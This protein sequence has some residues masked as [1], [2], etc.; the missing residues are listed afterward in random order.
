MLNS[1]R[2]DLCLDGTHF[3]LCAFSL[4]IF[5]PVS[6]FRNYVFNEVAHSFSGLIWRNKDCL[7]MVSSL[8]I[9]VTSSASG[10]DLIGLA[11]H[12]YL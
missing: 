10:R 8:S 6:Y 11:P 9:D 7:G 3:C 2:V 12:S 1:L 4:R 5:P